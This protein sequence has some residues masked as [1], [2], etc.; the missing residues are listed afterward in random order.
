MLVD[1]EPRRRREHRARS[2][3]ALRGP[4]RHT[5]SC[6]ATLNCT[7]T[8]TRAASAGKSLAR[9]LLRHLDLVRAP[10]DEL[11]MPVSTSGGYRSAGCHSIS[12]RPGGT[13]CRG[14]G[15][16]DLRLRRVAVPHPVPAS[17]STEDVGRSA[18]RSVAIRTASS[19]PAEWPSRKQPGTAGTRAEDLVDGAV[20]Q[21]DAL[22]RVAPSR[23]VGRRTPVAGP[24]QRHH[25]VA[26]VGRGTQQR[27]RA[28]ALGSRNTLRC[29]PLRGTRRSTAFGSG[30]SAMRPD[31]GTPSTR[32]T[33]G[34]GA[35]AHAVASAAGSHRSVSGRRC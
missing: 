21:R 30:T 12:R 23:R 10:G 20:G 8:V 33:R 22:F 14:R 5:R 4:T 24:V 19:Q 9:P 17:S 6:S 32:T 3:S 7:G 15:F 35:S 16:T 25:R 34:R 18:R 29:L 28:D 26:V 11:V 27:Q 2:A 13:R 1:H 31:I